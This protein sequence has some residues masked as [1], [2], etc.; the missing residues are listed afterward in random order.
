MRR[1]LAPDR[2][3][4]HVLAFFA[5]VV[6]LGLA[7]KWTVPSTEPVS[8]EEIRVRCR[9][10]GDV[11]LEGL[12]FSLHWTILRDDPPGSSQS[13]SIEFEPPRRA[14]AD[15]NLFL[16]IPALPLIRALG[17][18]PRPSRLFEVGTVEL[19]AVSTSHGSVTKAIDSLD[20]EIE[21]QA[22]ASLVVRIEPPLDPNDLDRWFVRVMPRKL[23]KEMFGRH[24]S[25]TDSYRDG[26]FH[27]AAIQPGAYDVQLDRLSVP[28]EKGF[29]YSGYNGGYVDSVRHDDGSP[30]PAFVLASGRNEIV[31][32]RKL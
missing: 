11:P 32:K 18:R 31:V 6:A 9:V 7:L 19:R 16:A 30:D 1:T 4:L 25:T 15:P 5:G 21:F 14:E 23:G 2:P 8:V 22:P 28:D 26:A 20:A 27:C 17:D 3:W 13:G 29:S 24:L 12:A 10:A